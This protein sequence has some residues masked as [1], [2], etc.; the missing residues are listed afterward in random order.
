MDKGACRI[1]IVQRVAE[2]DITKRL[3]LSPCMYLHVHNYFLEI[4][5]SVLYI[6]YL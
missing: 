5:E 3:T 2:L 4:S 6:S 1:H